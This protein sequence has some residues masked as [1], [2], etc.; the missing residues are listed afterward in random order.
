MQGRE[1]LLV[2][3]DDVTLELSDGRRSSGSLW[4][5]CDARVSWIGFGE[6]DHTGSVIQR[7]FAVAVE[8]ESATS[9]LVG[10]EPSPIATPDGWRTL[11]T[12]YALAYSPEVLTADRLLV[13][14]LS[15]EEYPVSQ[16]GAAAR[17]SWF[18][19]T[20]ANGNE[21]IGAVV[22]TWQ[23]R[24]DAWR[25][26]AGVELPLIDGSLHWFK[27][28]GVHPRFRGQRLGLGLLHHALWSLRRADGD[29][30]FLEARPYETEFDPGPVI[31]T[32]RGV[33]ALVRYYA[34]L[35]FRRTFPTERITSGETLMHYQFA[36]I[37]RP[38]IAGGHWSD[39]ESER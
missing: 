12:P 9:V 6:G 32:E 23:R 2:Y 36:G 25:R 30:A 35:G 22:E 7:E 4:L 3:P 14:T 1:G 37:S 17:G 10:E 16:L 26:Q 29:V 18:D 38:R 27:H 33:R 39:D 13:A 28:L 19:W 5:R 21:R 24:R 8:R 11:L 15:T 20:D 31:P 34:R